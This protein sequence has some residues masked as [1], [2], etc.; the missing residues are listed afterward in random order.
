MCMHF[1]SCM[2][3]NMRI[4]KIFFP[5]A[6][7]N[8]HYNEHSI[9]GWTNNEHLV[10][11]TSVNTLQ[12]LTVCRCYFC[13]P[14]LL[15]VCRCYFYAPQLLTVCRCYFYAPQLLTVCRCYFYAPQLLT[16]CTVGAISMSLNC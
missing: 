11:P 9:M 3:F 13:A 10:Q 5:K 1:C 12:L 16:V 8:N 4:V 15:T 6:L 14:Q 7:W 2:N